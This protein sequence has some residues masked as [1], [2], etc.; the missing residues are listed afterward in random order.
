MRIAS[1][2]SG[3]ITVPPMTVTVPTMLTT[4]VTPSS[5]QG[6]PVEQKPV[7][8]GAIGCPS[9]SGTPG[10]LIESKLTGLPAVGPVAALSLLE[11]NNP[12][13]AA[14]RKERKLRRPNFRFICCSLNN[15]F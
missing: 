11:L 1:T 14:P 2:T 4:G 9:T 12:A 15:S 5:A 10:E 6:L 13:P 8:M 3:F 7:V